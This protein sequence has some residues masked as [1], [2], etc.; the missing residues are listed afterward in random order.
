VALLAARDVGR[1]R[2][3]LVDSDGRKATQAA[4]VRGTGAAVGGRGALLL[5]LAGLL[6]LQ[7]V[8]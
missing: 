4:R 2:R 6:V 1:M 8:L 3:G 5:L 7:G